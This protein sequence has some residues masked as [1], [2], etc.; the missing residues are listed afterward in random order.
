M[1][2]GVG[3]LPRLGFHLIHRAE[4]S[5]TSILGGECR[6]PSILQTKR[7]GRLPILF[8][9]SQLRR[10]ASSAA[11]ATTTTTTP[12]PVGGGDEDK[13]DRRVWPIAAS[14][15][16]MGTA[17]GVII[18]LLPMLS[19]ELG[20]STAG[21]GQLV[22]SMGLAR[23]LLNIPASAFIDSF[24]RKP[25]LVGGPLLTSLS[26]FG[27]SIASS[28]SELLAWRLVTGGGGSLQMSGAQSYLA[29][30][31]TP[32]NRARTMAPTTI[33]FQAGFSIGPSLSGIL[34][35]SLGFRMPFVVVGGSILLV[36]L[37]NYLM[38]PETLARRRSLFGK[39]QTVQQQQQISGPLEQDDSP[40]PASLSS[41]EVLRTW[42]GFLQD[43]DTRRVAV[44]HCAFWITN[45]GSL[46]TLFP[47]LAASQ[48]ELG[49]AEIGSIFTANAILGAIGAQPSAW[50]S[51]R[52]GRKAALVPGLCLVSAGLLALPMVSTSW[53]LYSCAGLWGLGSA[54]VGSSA[55]AMMA[56]LTLPQNRSQALGLLRSAGDLGLLVGA[57]ALSY[58]AQ[59]SMSAAF[60][61]N[62]CGLLGVVANFALRSRETVIKA[63]SPPPASSSTSTSS[64]SSE[65]SPQSSKDSQVS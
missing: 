36:A 10:L 65:T 18:P 64:A 57:V 1:L 45:A 33:A 42:W 61:L 31:S 37:N 6:Q 4:A 3:R 62:G 24:G 7:L 14:S 43:G 23:L 63:S 55:T 11:A 47:L 13:L 40:P 49:V 30:I 60:V 25:A 56:D 41:S 46:L 44:L 58:V 15:L 22:G 59:F 19:T 26:M 2:S 20:I 52:F 9:P 29:D 54:L 50:F 35:Q 28:F 34:A 17:V 5:A 48:F 12:G 38:L 8:N 53:Q 51:D 16:V 27:T 32:K 21:F 39:T